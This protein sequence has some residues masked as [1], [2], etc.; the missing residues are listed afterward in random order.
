M[1]E[2]LDRI[3]V[4][5]PSVVIATES[6]RISRNT[7]QFGWIDTHLSMKGVN[8]LLINEREVECPFDKAFLR[9]LGLCFLSLR[10]ILVSG[11]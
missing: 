7:L 10:L 2:L 9:R 4:D 8:L 1:M 3:D 6:D 11:E 5:K